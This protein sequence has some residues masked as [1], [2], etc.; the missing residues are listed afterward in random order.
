MSTPDSATRRSSRAASPGRRAAGG[1]RS[2]ADT[3]TVRVDRVACSAHGVCASLL[4]RQI[5]LDEWGYPIVD[6]PTAP[7]GDAR[8]A[9][10]MCPAQA[11]YLA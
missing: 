2:T 9:V 4:P 1:A 6:S 8:T 11:L 5:R 3:A 7:A 10:T